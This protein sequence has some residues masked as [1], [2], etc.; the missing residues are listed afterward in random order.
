MVKR[1][2]GSG[3]EP[4]SPNCGAS[5]GGKARQLLLSNR[6]GAPTECPLKRNGLSR[7][8]ANP[9]CPAPI[10]CC[11]GSW[12][13]GLWAAFNRPLQCHSSQGPPPAPAGALRRLNQARPGSPNFNQALQGA[14]LRSP[15]RH[16]PRPETTTAWAAPSHGRGG[17]SACHAAPRTTP[18][19]P[20][21]PRIA[22]TEPE[23]GL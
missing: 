8:S 15:V 2:T 21:Q 20:N 3:G 14:R 5:A 1:P 17:L 4:S 22:P 6:C 16:A 9:P 10:R 18:A 7:P 19:A 11:G 12:G 13:F 23:G